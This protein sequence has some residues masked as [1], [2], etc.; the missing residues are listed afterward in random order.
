VHFVL[1]FAA[2]TFRKRLDDIRV[3]LGS[4]LIFYSGE[5]KYRTI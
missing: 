5:R 3:Q 4:G 1:D 2:Q